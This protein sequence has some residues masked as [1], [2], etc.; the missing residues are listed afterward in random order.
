MSQPRFK[1]NN[2]WPLIALFS[3]G[4]LVV[5][6]V[7]L[8]N[9]DSSKQNGDSIVVYCAAGVRLAVEEISRQFE[10]DLEVKVELEY[11]N[12]GVLANRLKTDKEGGL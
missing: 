3:L 9:R 6:V 1:R 2:S 7:S 5:L 11:A 4:I 8:T 10:R 12:S